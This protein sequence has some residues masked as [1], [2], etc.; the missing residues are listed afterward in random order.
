MRAK[1]NNQ[2]TKKIL[3]L[4]TVFFSIAATTNAQEYFYYGSF[5]RYY[6]D[7]A[8]NNPFTYNKMQISRNIYKEL[9]LK[10]QKKYYQNFRKDTNTYLHEQRLYNDG[11]YEILV[12]KFSCKGKVEYHNE[13]KYSDKGWLTMNKY[14]NSKAKPT[15][16]WERVIDEKGKLTETKSYNRKGMLTH[17][18]VYLRDKQGKAVES[19]SYRGKKHKLTTRMVYTYYPN[20]DKKTTARFN[21]K[22]KIKKVW[23]YACSAEGAEVRKMK[24]TVQVCKIAD[25]NKDGGFT[26][27]NRTIN[28]KGKLQ[29]TVS[30]YTKDSILIQFTRHDDKD[31]L[32]YKSNTKK[33][34]NGWLTEH[35]RYYVKKAK[36][37]VKTCKEYNND[38]ELVSLD[39]IYYKR[40]GKIS[41]RY[42]SDYKG[43]TQCL[44]TKYYKKGG[45]NIYKSIAYNYTD[46]GLLNEV[47]VFGENGIMQNKT[48]Y[49]YR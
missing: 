27:T 12:K 21:G 18:T 23:S 30:K 11:G 49:Q 34:E 24:D 41:S 39:K 6:Y 43:A 8:V 26:I 13:R 14:F 48:M 40:N 5:G 25:Y 15:Y 20:G 45:E 4:L 47:L 42:N 1:L 46:K 29:R 3:L 22:G 31:R 33:T 36:P 37:H 7:W 17:H 28:E 16:W 38:K 9:R 32:V 19:N 35:Y 2:I 10:E 44:K